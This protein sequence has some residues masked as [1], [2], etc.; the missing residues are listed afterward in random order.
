M[1]ITPNT[2]MR[3]GSVTKQ[4]AA[5]AVLSLVDKGII[6]L[7]DS[8][9]NIY[10]FEAFRR[11][12]IEQLIN[13]TSGIADAENAFFTEWDTSKIAENENLVEWYSRN[14]EPYFEPGQNGNTIMEPMNC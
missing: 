9:F 3:L 12:T 1:P 10:P 2:N 8:V 11:I 4:F 6:S 14:P 7:S 13:H 5:L